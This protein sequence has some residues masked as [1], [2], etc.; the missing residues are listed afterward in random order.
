MRT[1]SF[2]GGVQSTAVLVLA[3]TGRVQ[4][5]EFVFAN[6]G[7]DSEN[8]DTIAYVEQYAKPYASVHGLPFVELQKVRKSGGTE[9]LLEYTVRSSRSIKLPL[10]MKNGA[11]GRRKLHER[12]QNQR[13][14]GVPKA[15]RRYA[16]HSLHYRT[17][18]Q[19]G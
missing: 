10:Y 14:F 5:D 19:H 15:Q 1:F 2:G 7:N 12:I 11:P 4:Y 3:A 9:T 8:P 13:N 6:V 18:H 16:C 17:R